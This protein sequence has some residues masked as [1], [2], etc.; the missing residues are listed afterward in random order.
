M[1]MPQV[2]YLYQ[3]YLDPRKF[4]EQEKKTIFKPVIGKNGVDR[5]FSM[6][7]K[8]FVYFRSNCICFKSVYKRVSIV[9]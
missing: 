4:V 2:L 3:D 7:L 5:T 8:V 6:K 1:Q 9:M